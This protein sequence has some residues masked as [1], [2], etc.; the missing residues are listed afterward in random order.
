MCVR[1]CAAIFLFLC[2]AR[3]L[4][5]SF[6]A[7]T[8]VILLV[9]AGIHTKMHMHCSAPGLLQHCRTD[10]PWLAAVISHAQC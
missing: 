9:Q 2:A 7:E 10:T 4:A 3:G 1:V 5:W 6:A 8:I